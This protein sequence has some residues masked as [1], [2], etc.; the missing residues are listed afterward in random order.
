MPLAAG[1]IDAVLVQVGEESLRE[2]LDELG[3]ADFLADLQQALHI[4]LT[5]AWREVL[6]DRAGEQG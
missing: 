4:R 6:Q 2:L 3:C 5:A 1:Q